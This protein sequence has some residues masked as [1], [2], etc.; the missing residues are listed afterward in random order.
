[1]GI[2]G[3]R[4]EEE[5]H[6]EDERG[7]S[8]QGRKRE[9][10]KERERRRETER[11]FEAR[12]GEV[13]EVETGSNGRTRLFLSTTTWFSQTALLDPSRGSEQPNTSRDDGASSFKSPLRIS[14]SPSSPSS[15]TGCEPNP[16]A[17]ESLRLEQRSGGND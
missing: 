1:M 17:V 5:H 2:W 9:R 14:P 4:I 13:E 10:K 6:Y 15:C 8:F 7:I 11:G 16:P 12:Y 3:I